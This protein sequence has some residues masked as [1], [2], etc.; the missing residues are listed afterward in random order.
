MTREQCLAEIAE[1]DKEINAAL[2]N[3]P[4]PKLE[5]RPFPIGSW[6]LAV[7]TFVWWMF[8]SEIPYLQ[9]FHFRIMDYVFYGA[10]IMTALAVISTLSYLLR[11]RGG[12]NVAFRQA[13]EKVKVLQDR[14]RELQVRLKELE[15]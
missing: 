13:T 4:L 12:T 9:N 11:R 14:R 1:L 2:A 7:L 3:A 8:G 15:E 10:L 6:I 5:S